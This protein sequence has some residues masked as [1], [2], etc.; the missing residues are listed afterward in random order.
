MNLEKALAA[1]SRLGNRQVY[2]GY[3]SFCSALFYTIGSKHNA[4]CGNACGHK[5]Y[6]G[7]RSHNW[8]GGRIKDSWGYIKVY[9]PGHLRADSHGY[10]PEHILVMEK[11]I[12]RPLK[13]KETVHHKNGIPSDNRIGNLELMTIHPYGQRIKDLIRFVAREYPDEVMDEI[14]RRKNDKCDD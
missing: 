9:T 2:S 3:C 13:K 8:K 5:A 12:E 7:C 4:Y 14:L 10:V 6:R 1:A 11:F